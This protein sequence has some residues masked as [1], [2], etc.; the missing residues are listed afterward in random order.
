MSR[1]RIRNTHRD[2]GHTFM[3][4]DGP[5][6]MSLDTQQSDNGWTYLRFDAGCDAIVIPLTPPALNQLRA[7]LGDAHDR[8]RPGG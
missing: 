3:L 8:E 2:E 1:V 4:E 7:L 6:G 5:C